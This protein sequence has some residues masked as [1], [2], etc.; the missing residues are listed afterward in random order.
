MS[1]TCWAITGVAGF[2]GSHLLE[3]LLKE[4]H[5]V[6][7]LDNL[8]TGSER[9][10]EDVRRNVSKDQWA[11]FRFDTIDI[12]DRDALASWLRPAHT[13]LHQAAVGSVPK[14]LEAPRLFHDN[15][16]TGTLNVFDAAREAGVHSI[17]YASSSSVYGDSPALPKSESIIGD[18]LSPYAA[19]KRANEIYAAAY[20]SCY[21]MSITGLRYFNVFGPRQNP[22]GQYAAVIP[23][24]IDAFLCGGPIFINGDGS[25]SRDFCYVRNVVQANILAARR[26]HAPRS[27]LYNVACGTAISLT[28]LFDTIKVVLSKQRGDRSILARQPTFRDFRSG[29][30]PHS[31]ANCKAAHDDLGYR[32]TYDLARGLEETVAWYSNRG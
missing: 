27:P 14:S 28:A 26:S 32:P 6:I 20:S 23:Q 9:H 30:V 8:S 2:I 11:R 29:D 24:W 31:L 25:T 12:R 19:T 13:V 7:G 1:H 21:G 4:E 22:H 5:T 10:L 17:V 18:P 15:N 16:V 3:T